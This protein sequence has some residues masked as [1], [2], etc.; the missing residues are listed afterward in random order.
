MNFFNQVHKLHAQS[1]QLF[2]KLKVAIPHP[3]NLFRALEILHLGK[4]PL[5][6]SN[7]AYLLQISYRNK[8]FQKKLF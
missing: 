2:N 4:M 3:V 7:S 8:C 1:A 6:G 5:K